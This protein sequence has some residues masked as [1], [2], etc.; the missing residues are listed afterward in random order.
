MSEDTPQDPLILF[1][2]S[3]NVD[4]EPEE[5]KERDGIKYL[6]IEVVESKLNYFFK[7]LWDT[8]QFKYTVVVNELVGDLELKVF[9]PIAKVWL[10]RSGAGAVMIRQ[11][12]KDKSGKKLDTDVL[13]ISRKIPNAMEMDIGHLKADCIKN[14]AK[15]LGRAFGSDLL[16]DIKSPHLGVDMVSQEQIEAELEKVKGRDELKEL[17]LSLPITSQKD[18]SISNLFRSKRLSL[19]VLALQKNNENPLPVSAEVVKLKRGR[20]KNAEKN[21]N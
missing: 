16:R 12:S 9:H 4:P 11:K 15:S 20:K 13:D 17:F 6:P 18:R 5:L 14:A 10:T 8:A 19:K 2:N 3:L 21:G 1:Q 7:G